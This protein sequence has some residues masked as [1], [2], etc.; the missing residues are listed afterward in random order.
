MSQQ[1]T[2]QIGQE[3]NSSS[4][5]NTKQELIKMLLE[6]SPGDF[7]RLRSQKVHQKH[8]KASAFKATS[9]TSLDPIRK[10]RSSLQLATSPQPLLVSVGSDPSLEMSRVR[11]YFIF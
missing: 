8:R 6:M 9:P 10:K 11:P 3:S 1:S 7:E 2:V 5:G 4:D